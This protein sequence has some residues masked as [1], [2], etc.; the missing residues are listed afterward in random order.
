MNHSDPTSKTSPATTQQVRFSRRVL[1]V[2]AVVVCALWWGGLTFYAVVVV[3]LG[4]DLFGSVK[5][6]FLTQQVTVWL[7]VF[8]TLTAAVLVA[9]AVCSTSRRK[10]LLTASLFSVL[11]ASLWIMHARLSHLMD[12]STL[13]VADDAG[14]YGEHRIYLCLTTAQWLIALWHVW[15]GC[16]DS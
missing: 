2:L 13:S 15:V 4:T 11:Q 10:R 16:R 9:E 6:G 14:F 3:P 8:G 5:Q 7:N 12:S 1:R